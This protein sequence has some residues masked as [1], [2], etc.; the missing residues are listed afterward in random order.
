MYRILAINPGSTSTKVSVYE[1]E[2]QI[3]MENILHTEEE[4]STFTCLM[5]QFDYRKEII[6]DFLKRNHCDLY[7]ID[8]VVGRGGII[9][10]VQSGAYEMNETLRYALTHSVTEHASNLGGLL[11]EEIA[12]KAGKRAFIYDAP[13]VDEM[14]DLARLTGLPQIERPSLSHALN[15]RAVAHEIAATKGG[16]YAD[17]TAIVAHLGGG[18][19]LSL[20]TEGKMVDIISDDEGP[21]SP[22]RAGNIPAR[23]LIEMIFNENLDVKS[24]NAKLR[25]KGAG[26]RG[27]LGTSNGIAIEKA[28]ADG[29]Q[30]AAL[31]YEA[32]AFN[33]AKYIGLLATEVGGN[34]DHIILTGGMAHSKMVTKW[35][36]E[37]VS[38]IAPVEIVAGENEM[39]S[40]SLGV[41]R[42]LRGEEPVHQYTGKGRSPIF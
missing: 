15:M 31:C 40:L 42:V 1:D 24:A 38:F 3:F 12:K 37:R 39:R 18:I 34:V 23:W 10:P 26:L 22:E 9:Q 27:Y 11:A 19:T 20:H 32:M 30:K 13:A 28:I 29:D 8:A 2:N 35:I 14:W 41:L 5:D 6:L 25:G 7:T 33:V 21:F 16:K 4:L 36:S 17:Y